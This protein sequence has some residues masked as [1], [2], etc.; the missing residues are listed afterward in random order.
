MVS[1]DDCWELTCAITGDPTQATDELFTEHIVG[2][3][4]A[5]REE[6]DHLLNQLA[7]AQ[8]HVDVI[9][10]KRAYVVTPWIHH[11]VQELQRLLRQ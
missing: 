8:A 11:D 2:M 9:V 7:A 6:R 1:R 10:A 3:I 4:D 5:L